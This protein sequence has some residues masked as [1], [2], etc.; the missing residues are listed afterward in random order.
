MA[1]FADQPGELLAAGDVRALADVHEQR[2]FVQAQRL[3]PGQERARPRLGNPSRR[4]P[5]QRFDDGLRVRGRRAAAAAHDV[6]QPVAREAGQDL[7]HLRGGLVVAAQFV[8]Q[9][10]VGMD[11]DERVGVL[12]DLG[13]ERPQRLRAQGA[14]QAEGGR[15]G[16]AQRDP[17]RLGGLAGQRA[18]AGIDDGAG[19]PHRHVR[20][21][22]ALEQ[23][24][25]G[26]HG[27]L[28]VE[29]VEDR[30]DEQQVGPAVE[31]RLGLFG[32]RGDQLDE[33]DVAPPGVVHVGR[34][35]AGPVGGRQ[36]AGHEPRAVGRPPRPV[37]GGLAGQAGRGQVDLAHEMVGAVVRLRD[38]GAVEGVGRD[39]VGAG[40][41]VGAVDLA[42]DPRLGQV[43]D[44]VVALQVDRV[45][46]QRLAAEG[47]LVQAVGLDHRAH[48]AVQDQDPVGGQAAQELSRQS[49]HHHPVSCHPAGAYPGPAA[50][51]VARALGAT[52]V[53]G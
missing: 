49:A 31:Q 41:E 7:G 17:E 26:E 38:R 8:G 40:L 1:A 44:V 2:R 10:G 21:A 48:G 30:L 43:E 28:G 34:N 29:R 25:H 52:G 23:L 24:A 12:R 16:V 47:R 9:A 11:R 37:V 14:V 39:E 19:D 5:A 18:A 32:V 3:E 27:G 42:D 15:I 33:G 4:Q 13:Q 35:R 22:A 6:D 51:P 50:T 53:R 36:R 20:R 46:A 45:V